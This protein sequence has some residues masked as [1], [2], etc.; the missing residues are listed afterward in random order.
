VKI[1][2][3]KLDKLFSQYIR[4]RA[5][6]KCQYCGERKSLECSHFHSRRKRSTRWDERNAIAVCFTCHRYLDE[7]PNKHVAFFEKLL[8]SEEFEKLNIRAETVAKN[9]DTDKLIEY[10][11]QKIKE[12]L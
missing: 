9:I 3:S 1:H 6:G 8:G 5:N 4:L 11:T 2:V 10:Y 12:I 7:N